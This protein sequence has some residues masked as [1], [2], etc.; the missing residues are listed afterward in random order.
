MYCL[1]ERVKTV[2][3]LLKESKIRELEPEGGKMTCLEVAI[4]GGHMDVVQYLIQ[5]GFV[6]E[7]K[8]RDKAV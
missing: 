5:Q 2:E 7:G 6:V 3:V 1:P 4:H 8:I